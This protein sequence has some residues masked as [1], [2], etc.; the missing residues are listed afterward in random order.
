MKRYIVKRLLQTIIVIIGVTVISFGVLFMTGDPT[1]LLLGDT[2]RGMSQEKIEEFRHNMGFD[3]PWLVQYADYMKNVLKGDLGTS[4]YHRRPNSVII[5]ESMPNTIKL[6]AAAMTLT[7]VIAV[8]LGIVSATKRNSLIDRF[9][10]SFGLLGQSLPVFWL[11]IIMILIFGVKLRW[12]PVSGIGG[13][14]H[15]IMPTVALGLFSCARDARMIRSC[16]LDVLN[17]DYVR[18]ARAKGLAERVVIYKHAL[19]NALIPVITMLGMEFGFLLGGAVITET[20]FSW[21]GIGRLTINAILTK[22][23][24]LVQASVIVLAL[25]FVFINLFVDLVYTVLDPKVSMK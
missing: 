17:Q 1:V 10:M 23:I 4:Y 15:M 16:M 18:T 14:K 19:K 9:T 22:D 5:G 20:I 11:G 13:F 2:A 3:R 21:P 8:P 12:L 24:P 7:I 6:A 25:I